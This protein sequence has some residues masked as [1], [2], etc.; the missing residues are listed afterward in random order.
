MIEEDTHPSI[1]TQMHVHLQACDV[2]EHKTHT[3]YTL[4]N[5]GGKIYVLIEH[6]KR[7]AFS[8]VKK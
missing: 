1:C 5:K 2:Q 8:C 7:K 4:K 6:L 3:T